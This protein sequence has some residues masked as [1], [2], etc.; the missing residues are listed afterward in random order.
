M[1]D[2]DTDKISYIRQRL[3]RPIVL[4]GLMGAGKSRI[5]RMLGHA[6]EMSFVDAD[7]EIEC[8]AGMSVS[9]IFERYGEPYFRDGEKRVMARL[10]GEGVQVIAAGGGAVMTPETADAIWKKSLSLW[11]KADIPVIVERTARNDRRPLLQTENPEKVLKELAEKRYP[12]YQKADI[13]V[14][15]LDGMLDHGKSPQP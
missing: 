11:I 10:L 8:A 7:D 2:F 4:I 15:R 6:L 3:D 14:E 13:V 5:G 12:V 9:E 1:T